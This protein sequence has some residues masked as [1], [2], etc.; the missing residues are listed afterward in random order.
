[1][2]NIPEAIA[3]ALAAFMPPDVKPSLVVPCPA[4]DGGWRDVGDRTVMC[5]QC[6]GSGRVATAGGE[7]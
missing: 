4:C 7:P 2:N 3:Q 1:M 6:R 5:G